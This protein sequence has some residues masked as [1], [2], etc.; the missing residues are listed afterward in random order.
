MGIWIIKR[1]TVDANNVQTKKHILVENG[2]I[3]QVIRCAN[4]EL[5]QTDGS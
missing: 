4:G 2:K 3:A 1:I 5:P